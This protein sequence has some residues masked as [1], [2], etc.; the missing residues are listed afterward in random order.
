LEKNSIDEF[1]E[2]LLPNTLLLIEPKIDGMAI[3]LQ[4]RDGNLEKSIS[5]KVIDVTSKITEI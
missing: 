1:L 3:A 5:R 4:Y 2:G